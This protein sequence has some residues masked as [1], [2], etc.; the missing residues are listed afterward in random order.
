MSS[1]INKQD[2]LHNAREMHKGWMLAEMAVMSGQDY[3]IG[4]RRLRR[5]DLL[6]IAQRIKYWK[7]EVDRLEGRSRICVQQVIPRDT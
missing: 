1:V 5:A 7:A 4:S 3:S 6:D 2:E